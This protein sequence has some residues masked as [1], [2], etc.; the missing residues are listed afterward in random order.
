MELSMEVIYFHGRQFTSTEGNLLPR[1]AIYFH[2]RFH[3]SLGNF[4]VT[5]MEVNLFPWKLRW[6]SVEVGLL[7]WKFPWKLV[8]VDILPWKLV[9]ASMEVQG[10]FHLRWKWKPPLLPSIAASTNMFRGS[11]HELP[12]TPTYFHLHPRITQFSNCFDK[13]STMVHRLPFD[14][15][16]RNFPRVC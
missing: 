8:E 7:P 16:Q 1:K 2:A 14:L 6:K 15:L 10:S 13:T 9:E 11:F 12:Y 3:R 5:S 4:H